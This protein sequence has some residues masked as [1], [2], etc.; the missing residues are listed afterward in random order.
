[1][2]DFRAENISESLPDGWLKWAFKKETLSVPTFL[3]VSS[4]FVRVHHEIS[5]LIPNPCQPLQHY[6]QLDIFHWLQE[7]TQKHPISFVRRIGFFC[8]YGSYIPVCS[9]LWRPYIRVHVNQNGRFLLLVPTEVKPY[10]APYW[11]RSR[12][13]SRKIVRTNG[14]HG[15]Y[16]PVERSNVSLSNVDCPEV[17]VRKAA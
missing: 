15:K 5:N 10:P 1:M 8:V 9:R 2:F 17:M 6:S 3:N 4:V 7:S 12:T 16:S 11:E 14:S 13:R